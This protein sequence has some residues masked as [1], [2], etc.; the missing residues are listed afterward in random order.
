MDESLDGAH[1]WRLTLEHSPIGMNLVALD[2]RAVRLTPTEFAILSLLARYPGKIVTRSRLLGELW[3]PLG[4]VEEGSLRVH[5][6]AIRKKIED[7]PSAPTILMTEP[8]I[9][10]RLTA[11]PRDAAEA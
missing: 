11:E 7:E 3:G 8:G 6:A 4:E 5:I 10:Y 9:G 2:G 1:L